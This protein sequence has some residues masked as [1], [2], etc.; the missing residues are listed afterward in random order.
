MSVDSLKERLLIVSGKGGVGKTAL[1]SGLA[2]ACAEHEKTILVTL[3]EHYREHPFF[4]RTLEYEPS[5]LGPGLWGA[6][7]DSLSAIRE[8][9]RRKLPFG[10]FYDAFL[11]SRVFRDFVD[12]APG[13]QE[14]MSLGKVYDLATASDF[15]RI[16]VDAPSTGHLRTLLDVPAATLKAVQVGPLNHNA[17]KIQDL[18]LDPERTRLLVVTLPEEMPV[19][20]ALELQAFCR[21]RRMAVGPILLNQDVPQRFLPEEVMAMRGLQAGGALA[22]GRD[23]ALAEAELVHVQREAVAALKGHQVVRLPRLTTHDPAALVASL[24]Q[25]F[26]MLV[27]ARD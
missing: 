17:R 6:T 1:A 20:E 9:A 4:G 13:F 7:I 18:L 8:Y 27:D 19:R 21:E 3:D 25:R 10:V 11:K 14:L 22:T 26:A 12:A 5:A 16:V 2:L 15:R 23:A 24:A